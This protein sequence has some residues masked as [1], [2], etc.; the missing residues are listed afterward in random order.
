M[1]MSVNILSVV[2]ILFLHLL[3]LSATSISLEKFILASPI[4]PIPDSP[5]LDRSLY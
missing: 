2:T 5:P 3:L 1:C 4:F